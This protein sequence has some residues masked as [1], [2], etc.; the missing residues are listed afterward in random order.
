MFLLSLFLSFEQ[1]K[2][3]PR[4]RLCFFLGYGISQKG[5]RYYD[6]ISCRLR[7][8]CHVEFWEHQT[9][10][11]RQHFSLISYSMTPIFTN[12]SV[13]LYPNLVK[14]FAL[15]PSSLDVPSSI[16][17][18]AAGSPTPD[19]APSAPLESSIDLRHS[20]RVRAPSSHFTDYHCL[21]L[22]LSVSLISIV[23][24]ALIL[25]GSKL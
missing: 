4:S 9:F 20:H 10:S 14:D 23:R 3:E 1:N 17:S 25:F 11:S 7:I 24:L 15:P 22:L 19:P 2:L 18:P 8:S 13:D 16:S 12:H 6:P 5:F 21:Y